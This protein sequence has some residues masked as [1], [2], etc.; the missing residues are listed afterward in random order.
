MLIE[1]LA[2]ILIAPFCDHIPNLVNSGAITFD[3]ARVASTRPADFE[4]QMRTL[5]ASDRS[6]RA[7]ATPVPEAG[8]GH[9]SAPAEIEGFTND[10]FPG[11]DD[12]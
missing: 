1:G 7:M 4:L 11:R 6:S 3:V 2:V 8:N 10:L 9:S 5:T 12:S